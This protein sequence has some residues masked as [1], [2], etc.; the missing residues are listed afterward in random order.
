M[1][2]IARR[3]PWYADKEICRQAQLMTVHQIARTASKNPWD[4]DIPKPDGS[5]DNVER[6]QPSVGN[7]EPESSPDTSATVETT[8]ADGPESMILPLDTVSFW[9]DDQR[10]FHLV[11]DLD[12]ASGSIIENALTEARDGLFQNGQ[13]DVSTGPIP[14]SKS[15]SDRSMPSSLP[16]DARASAPTFTG[17]RTAR[18]PTQRAVASPTQWPSTSPATRFGPTSSKSMA[19]PSRLA[20]HNTPSCTNQALGHPPRRRLPSPRLPRPALARRSSHRSLGPGRPH[21]YRQS[22]RTVQQA[23]PHQSPGSAGHHGSRRRSG[24]CDVHE[25]V[26]TTLPSVR[27]ETTASGRTISNRAFLCS[28]SSG[29]ART[30]R[31]T[32]A[33]LQPARWVP[34][35]LGPRPCTH[36]QPA[37]TRRLNAPDEIEAAVSHL[38]GALTQAGRRPNMPRACI[39]ITATPS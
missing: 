1:S 38:D 37:T 15:P 25:S 16:P 18:R 36:H 10:R 35:L 13:V 29:H 17:T 5:V 21:G 34:S 23:S 11:G 14:F 4:I 22:D 31:L 3:V 39:V 20:V 26:R 27:S 24:R 6:P 9:W 33:T 8:Q 28:V 2:S 19:S 30:A 7:S 32:M 12:E